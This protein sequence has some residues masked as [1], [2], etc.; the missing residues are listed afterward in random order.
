MPQNFNDLQAFL[1]VAQ[2]RSFTKAAAQ[3]GV[4]QSA[5]SHTIRGLESKLGVRLLT[6][7]TRSVSPTEAGERLLATIS[8]RFEE[9]TAELIS[10]SEFRDKPAGTIR[11]NAAEHGANV[12]WPKLAKFLPQYP[13]IK[14]ELNVN[15][16][17]IDIVEQ[18]YDMGVRL[19]DRIAKDMI[20]VRIAP[21][22]CM[23][24]VGSPEYF[25]NHPIPKTPGDLTSHNCIN[26]RYQTHG[27]IY[28]WEFKKGNQELNVKVEGQ[29]VFNGSAPMLKAALSGFGLAYVPQ[30]SA[31]EHLDAG[32]LVHVLQDWSITFP[33]YHIYYPSRRQS[34]PAFKLLVEALR[35]HQ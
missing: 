32:R 21:D 19:G 30:D 16:G 31:Q 24:V 26:L 1:A 8:P 35:Y 3:M 9:I 18:Q 2:V 27:G 7:T 11:I 22:L 5:L 23:A 28:A 14:V 20:A 4:S 10:L 6:R 29:L 34:S 13:D 25:L 12:L 17:M 15:Y 33:G